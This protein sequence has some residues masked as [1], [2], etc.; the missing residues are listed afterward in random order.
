MRYRRPATAPTRQA[1]QA[2]CGAERQERLR[3]DCGGGGV[4]DEQPQRT[5]D[6]HPTNPRIRWSALKAWGM[7]VAKRRGLQK[8]VVAVARKLGMT[9]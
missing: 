3:A 9:C 2:E 5:V 8:A 7:G 1:D 6:L 4:V